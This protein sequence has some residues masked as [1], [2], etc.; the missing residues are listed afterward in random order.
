MGAEAGDDAAALD[1]AFCADE[2]EVDQGEGGCE[3][4]VRD[5]GYGDGVRSEGGDG[6]VGSF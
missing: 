4:G 2:D 1:N 6:G 5:R 3:G